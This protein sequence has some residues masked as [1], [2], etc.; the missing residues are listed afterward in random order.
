MSMR[1]MEEQYANHFWLMFD[2]DRLIVF[3]DGMVTNQPDLKDEMYD[4]AA[5]YDENGE[6]QM[7][8][9]L[10]TL[11]EYRRNG[12]AG[13]LIKCAIKDARVQK[14]KGLVLTCKE[15]LISYYS[16]FGFKSEG[17]SESIHGNAVWYQMRL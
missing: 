11:P 2:N 10:N 13:K 3:V 17:I 15:K 7:I 5:M 8:F 6:W 16:S 9:G 14:R 4:N 12:Y 1:K